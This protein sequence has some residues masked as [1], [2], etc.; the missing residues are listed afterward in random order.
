MNYKRKFYV[1]FKGEEKRKWWG[2]FLDKRFRHCF[3][4]TDGPNKDALVINPSEGGTG[5]YF[6]SKTAYAMAIES[7][8]KGFI[9]A[10]YTA[11]ESNLAKPRLKF[12][13]TCVGICKDF[14]GI[15]KWWVIT[16][17]QLYRE[18]LHERTF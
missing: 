18:V 2:T 11:Q 8:H 12:F 4:I 10:E 9:V 6:Y 16:P 3:L 17:K 5:V 7:I 13:R 15:K 1:V 14:L